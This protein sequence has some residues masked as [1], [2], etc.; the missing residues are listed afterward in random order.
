MSKDLHFDSIVLDCHNDTVLHIVDEKI[1]QPVKDLGKDTDLDIDLNKA[2]KGGLDIGYFAAFSDKKESFSQAN[3]TILAL[4]NSMYWTEKN[5]Q[6]KV[7][8]VKNYDEILPVIEKEK[9]A[10][11]PTIEGAY[12]FVDER[13]LELVEQYRDLG[14]QVIAYVWNSASPIATGTEGDKD[15]G[16]TDLG[17][18]LTK[19]VNELGIVIDVSHM[20]EKT[21]WDV[22]KESKA[23]I[24]ASHS[25]CKSL[26]NHVRNL[27]D[28]QIKAIAESRGVVNINFWWELLGEEEEKVS[29]ETLVDHIDY[30]RDLVGVDYIGLGSDF[31][32]ASMPKDLGS[33]EDLPKI[34]EELLK[35][36]YS[37]EEVRK[38]LGLNNLRVLKEVQSLAKEKENLDLDYSL[39]LDHGDKLDS[40]ELR[41]DLSEV[42]Y[43]SI[44]NGEEVGAVY[45][46]DERLLKIENLDKLEK[47]IYHIVTF[48]L[49]KDK[50]IKRITR[51]FLK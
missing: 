26:V 17:R 12:S 14:V 27:T 31:D 1:G 24:I 15:R 3:H 42:A 13:A 33:V 36:G 6:D 21:F 48:E 37:E 19:R 9:L 10:M 46:A 40:I 22:C 51:I 7:E 11:L 34:S 50:K 35:R 25:C 18:D 44:V 49:E 30:V 41:A 47:D 38:I 28:E 43:R 23:P 32:G 45:K 29:I 4:L 2:K 39:S 16:L 20:N 5:N 8:I